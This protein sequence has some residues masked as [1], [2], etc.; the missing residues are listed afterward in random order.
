MHG[1][2]SPLRNM[3]IFMYLVF[4]IIQRSTIQRRQAIQHA[5]LNRK[6]E[7]ATYS[8]GIITIWL[9]TSA[10]ACFSMPTI[11]I[12][13]TESAM[14][15]RAQEEVFHMLFMRIITMKLTMRRQKPPP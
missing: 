5:Y 14:E 3:P 6:R 2:V 8:F 15:H 12:L 10:M 13:Q 11:Q 4:H 1:L 9:C 7:P